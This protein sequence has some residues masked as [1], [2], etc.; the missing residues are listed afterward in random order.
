MTLLSKINYRIPG[1]SQNEK[2]WY[3]SEPIDITRLRKFILIYNFTLTNDKI[4]KVLF[5]FFLLNLE[6]DFQ[7]RFFLIS[8]D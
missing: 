3:L 2:F 4:P 1:T 5:L 6:F 8:E 7:T